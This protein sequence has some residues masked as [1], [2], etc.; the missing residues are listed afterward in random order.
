MQVFEAQVLQLM[1]NIVQP[2]TIGNGGV[3]VHGFA[4][5]ALRFFM[6]HRPQGAHVVQTI[7]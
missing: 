6:R 1:V 4:G 5:D 2:Q 3:N 7:R